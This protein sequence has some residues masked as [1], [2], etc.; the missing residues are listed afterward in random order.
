MEPPPI[1][2]T[3]PLASTMLDAVGTVVPSGETPLDEPLVGVDVADD[4]VAALWLTTMTALPTA[5]VPVRPYPYG[6]GAALTV[7]PA[8]PEPLGPEAS[9]SHDSS[10]FP[11]QSHPALVDTVDAAVPPAPDIATE[12]GDT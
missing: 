2:H 6:F 3:A 9:A 4:V 8:A 11:I 1:V 5:T 12:T 10:A 7:I